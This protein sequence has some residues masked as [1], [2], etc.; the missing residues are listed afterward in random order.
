M[1]LFRAM[2]FSKADAALSQAH[3]PQTRAQGPEKTSSQDS[4]YRRRIGRNIER[5]RGSR[6]NLCHCSSL[7]RNISVPIG[8]VP[9]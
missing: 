4:G 9:A 5:Y 1:A 3:P 6:A 7:S 8:R 2:Q